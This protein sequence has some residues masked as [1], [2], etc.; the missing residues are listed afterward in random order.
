MPGQLGMHRLA[1]W[2]DYH[3]AKVRRKRFDWNLIA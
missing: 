1:R 2:S 3:S